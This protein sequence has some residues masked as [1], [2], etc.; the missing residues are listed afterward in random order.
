M[1][2]MGDDDAGLTSEFYRMTYWLNLGDLVG[3]W[4]PPK[5]D[6]FWHIVDDKETGGCESQYA[7]LETFCEFIAMGDD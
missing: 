2:R 4:D 6:A 7:V 1:D 5:R 3:D